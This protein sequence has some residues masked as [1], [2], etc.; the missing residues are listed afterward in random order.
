MDVRSNRRQWTGDWHDCYYR[1][2]DEKQTNNA[3]AFG[4]TANW[5]DDLNS[6]WVDLYW[7]NFDAAPW[8]LQCSV[9]VDGEMTK[10]NFWPHK[11]KAQVDYQKVAEGW[12]E[13]NRLIASIYFPDEEEDID[14]LE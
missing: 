2:D 7:P 13:V 4:S 12:R 8:H 1:W 10:L 6:G 3:M 9:R 5:L 11:A 14:V